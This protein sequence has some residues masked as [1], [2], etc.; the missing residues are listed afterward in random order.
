MEREVVR[1]PLLVTVCISM[2]LAQARARADRILHS[3]IVLSLRSIRA[4][5]AV[6]VKVARLG[7]L[8]GVSVGY[9]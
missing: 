7:R 2:V 9:S 3:S 1:V 4:R 5:L 8:L 6:I